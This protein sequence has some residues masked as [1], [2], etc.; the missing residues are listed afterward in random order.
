M[1]E[2]RTGKDRS[3]KW[4]REKKKK[5]ILSIEALFG[6]ET[7]AKKWSTLW[8]TAKKNKNGSVLGKVFHLNWP[9]WN[10]FKVFT[11]LSNIFISICAGPSK[12][13]RG[14]NSWF[15]ISC[16]LLLGWNGVTAPPSGSWHDFQP[17]KK[18]KKKKNLRGKNSNADGGESSVFFSCAPKHISISQGPRFFMALILASQSPIFQEGMFPP[19]LGYEV[20][21]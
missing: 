15:G 11:R 8:S 3:C 13:N 1:Q 12:L 6:R 9:G 7:F 17:R 20:S 5:S 14:A 19:F 21:L 10:A 16:L 2:I 18:I 4:G